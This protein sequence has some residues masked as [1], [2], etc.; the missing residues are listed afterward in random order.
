[1]FAEP[2]GRLL[3]PRK[4]CSESDLEYC[5]EEMRPM[6]KLIQMLILGVM[7]VVQDDADAKNAIYTKVT[8]NINKNN[9]VAYEAAKEYLQKWP[10]DDDAIAKYLKDFVTKYEAAMRKQNCTKFL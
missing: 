7:A 2:G 4:S 9:Q 6:K 5:L 10:N 3:V 8:E 1:M